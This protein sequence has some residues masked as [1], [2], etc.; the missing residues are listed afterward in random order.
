MAGDRRDYEE[1]PLDPFEEWLFYKIFDLYVDM[2]LAIPFANRINGKPAGFREAYPGAWKR[3][4]VE[5]YLPT[6][7]HLNALVIRDWLRD[8]PPEFFRDLWSS[9]PAFYSSWEEAAIRDP[10]VVNDTLTIEQVKEALSTWQTAREL[11]LSQNLDPRYFDQ[12]V[13]PT[14]R[15]PG[16]YDPVRDGGG[17]RHPQIEP[18]EPF[19]FQTKRRVQVRDE[20]GRFTKTVEIRTIKTLDIPHTSSLGQK[21]RIIDADRTNKKPRGAIARI[22]TSPPRKGRPASWAY[23]VPFDGST[24]RGKSIEDRRHRRRAEDNRKESIQ[25]YDHRTQKER[26]IE[27]LITPRSKN[28]ETAQKLVTYFDQAKTR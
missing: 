23:V 5:T 12:V 6:Y 4:G 24:Y 28:F 15:D 18:F 16:D 9:R 13:F 19:V 7:A 1:P 21:I 26:V 25:L 8:M 14:R 3:H 27:V 17:K 2:G 22:Q 11:L 20:R 10:D